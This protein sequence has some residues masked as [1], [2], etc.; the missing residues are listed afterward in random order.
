MIEETGIAYVATVNPDGSPNLS[1]KG[2]LKVI[3]ESALAFADI[4][5]PGTMRNL[6]QN[7]AIEINVL[8]PF[9]RRGYRFR[10]PRHDLAGPRPDR[11]ARRRAWRAISDTG[12][13]ADR[14][15][16]GAPV[17]LADL[18]AVRRI[19]RNRPPQMG[20]KAGLPPLACSRMIYGRATGAGPR[21]R[22]GIR[23]IRQLS[24]RPRRRASACGSSV[25]RYR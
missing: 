13:R 10:G 8:D 3:G 4:A 5:S 21:K 16:S 6:A 2:T 24:L 7:P 20:R 14:C 22:A 17:D 25:C 11:A 1:P 9:L 12:R 15:R 18:H 19:G 23:I